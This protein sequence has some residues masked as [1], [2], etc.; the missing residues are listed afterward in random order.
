[1]PAIYAQHAL[2]QSAPAPK[3]PEPQPVPTTLLREQREARDA[4]LP[5][6][7]S[8]KDLSAMEIARILGMASED[9][10][11]GAVCRLKLPRRTKRGHKAQ[12]AS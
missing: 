6:L 2:R 8:N 7:W 5:G 4:R 9:A 3:A 12:R 1:M 11:Y 10:V